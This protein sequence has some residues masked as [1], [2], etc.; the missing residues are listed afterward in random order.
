MSVSAWDCKTSSEREAIITCL[1]LYFCLGFQ[2]RLSFSEGSPV[3]CGRQSIRAG[4]IVGGSD[5]YD[6]EF[7]WT[8]RLLN[9]NEWS[10][11]MSMRWRGRQIT[12]LIHLKKI[13]YKIALSNFSLSLHSL[14]ELSLT[15]IDF[16]LCGSRKS[17]QVWFILLHQ[18]LQCY[19]LLLQLLSSLSSFFPLFSILFFLL[20]CPDNSRE[21]LA[22]F[23]SRQTVRGNKTRQTSWRYWPVTLKLSRSL[24]K[25]QSSEKIREDGKKITSG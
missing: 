3:D 20:V 12:I 14:C 4:R 1:S 25:W 19:L 23:L 15:W 21:W 9:I 10:I 6:G 5:A 2:R 13:F 8:V 24:G 18:H 11:I 16:F 22:E 7:P 17:I